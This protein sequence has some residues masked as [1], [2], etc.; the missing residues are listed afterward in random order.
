MQEAEES[1]RVRN[2][3]N[4]KTYYDNTVKLQVSNRDA[5]YSVRNKMIRAILIIIGSIKNKKVQLDRFLNEASF[6][7]GYKSPI[8]INTL[9]W[10]ND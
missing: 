6:Y 5:N 2:I 1:T 7:S 8:G 4:E 3:G 9:N 10:A